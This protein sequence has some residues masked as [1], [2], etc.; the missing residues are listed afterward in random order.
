MMVNLNN[1]LVRLMFEEDK[2]GF[3]WN[4]NVYDILVYNL[5]EFLWLLIVFYGE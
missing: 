2:I 3:I 1:F 4:Y 5:L